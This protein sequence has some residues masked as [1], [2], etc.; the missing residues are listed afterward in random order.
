VKLRILVIHL[1]F[2]LTG[3]VT[4]MLGPLLPL[5]ATQWH[6]N[7]AQAGRLFLVQFI[8]SPTGS[9]VAS[10]VLSRWGAAWTVPIGMFMIAFGVTSVS[11]GTLPSAIVGIALY[12]AGL[13]FALPSTNLLVFE[14]V[15]DESAAALNILNFS[16]TLGA[17]AAPMAIIAMLQ[18]IGLRGFLLLVGALIL[19]IAAI[20]V[21]A[22]PK[23]G[24]VEPSVRQGKL[25]PDQRVLFAVM[26]FVFLFLYVGIENG[27]AGWVPTFSIRSQQTSPGMTAFVQSSFWAAILMGRLMA[28]LALRAVSPVRLVLFGLA[29]AATGILLAVGS[30]SV[31]VLEAG[32]L[33]SGFGLAAVFPTGISI[34]AEWYGTGGT[35]S[36]VLGCCGLGGALVPWLVGVV[37]DRSHNLRL[38]LAVTLACLVVAALAFHKLSSAAH[39]SRSTAARA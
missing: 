14:M 24:V 22:F 21:V 33:L 39:R 8:A 13:G 7:D 38:G 20:E 23:R 27:F 5:F 3:I 36:I 31:P 19:I 32:V 2:A 35:G 28:P 4:T 17:L 25:A 12:G 30:P 26:A 10:K 11:L 37:S 16:W 15:K 29:A 1:G 6:F 9:L 34:F 18:P